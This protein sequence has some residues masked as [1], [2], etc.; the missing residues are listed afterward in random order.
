MFEFST[1]MD[2]QENNNGGNIV[3]RES[4][5][6]Q[7]SQKNNN[8]R[9]DETPKATWTSGQNV[10]FV[11]NN[12]WIKIHRK[13]VDWEWFTEPHTFQVFMYLLLT[14]NHEEKQWKGVTVKRGQKIVGRKSLAQTLHI[15]EQSVRTALNHLK[16]TNEITIKTTSKYSLVTIQNWDKYQ[17]INQQPN[18]QLTNNQPTTNHKQEVKNI[19]SKEIKNNYGQ[20]ENVLLT[21]DE[22]NSLSEALTEPILQNLISQLDEY[23]ESTGKKYQSHRATI[24][25][26]ARRRMNEHAQKI[27]NTKPLSI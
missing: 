5:T 21:D 4:V 8:P 15:S 3:I 22:Y 25:T 9:Y 24:Q 1:G 16:S 12:G 23:I 17:Q 2:M 19:R 6:G 7:A 11:M 14:A 13:I 27:M 18:Q 20:F 10:G 26:W